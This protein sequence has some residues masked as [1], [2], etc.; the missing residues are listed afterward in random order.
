[1]TA[2]RPTLAPPR[3]QAIAGFLPV[4]LT[5]RHHRPDDPGDLVRQSDRC[6][7]RGRRSSNCNS[8]AVADLLTGFA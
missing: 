7:L 3:G 2:D 1:M 8:H 4:C 6:D 5:A